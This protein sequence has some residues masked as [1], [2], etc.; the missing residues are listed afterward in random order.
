MIEEAAQAR[1]NAEN[2]L[3]VKEAEV[4]KLKGVVESQKA[5]IADLRAA[6]KA[7]KEAA[8]DVGKKKSGKGKKS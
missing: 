7:V 2:E 4:S 6:K 3:K 8:H 1:T 5:T